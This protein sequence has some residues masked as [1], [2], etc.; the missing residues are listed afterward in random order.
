MK[1]NRKTERKASILAVAVSVV[2]F[3]NWSIGRNTKALGRYGSDF[4]YCCFSLR[5]CCLFCTEAKN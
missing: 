1:V 4:L 2:F 3:F 5:C